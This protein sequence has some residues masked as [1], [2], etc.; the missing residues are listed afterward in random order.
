MSRQRRIV[1]AGPSRPSLSVQMPMLPNFLQVSADE[2]HWLTMPV[3]QMHPKV[4][5]R[6]GK[7]WVELLV[8]KSEVGK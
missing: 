8:A 7:A 3:A 4:L 1:K 6:V 2:K 5:R